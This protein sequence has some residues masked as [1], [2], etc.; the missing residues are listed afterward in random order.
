MFGEE[1]PIEDII[2]EVDSDITANLSV[3]IKSV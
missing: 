3:E 2:T 1:I